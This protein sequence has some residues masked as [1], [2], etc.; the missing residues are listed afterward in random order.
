MKRI[1]FAY[2]IL[3]FCTLIIRLDYT[4]YADENEKV[5]VLLYHHLLK[6]KE[7]RNKGNA[8]IVSVENFERQ[9]EYLYDNDYM[10]ITIEV[11]RYMAC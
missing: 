10:T 1:I 9:M 2:V 5:I 7:N 4:V 6:E 11:M 8:S 3:I